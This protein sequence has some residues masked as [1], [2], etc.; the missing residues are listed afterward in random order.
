MQFG[1]VLSEL[2]IHYQDYVFM[3]IGSGKGRALIMA[4]EFPF[5]R[6]VGVELS[7]RLHEAAQSNLLR[8]RTKSRK[9][10]DIETTLADAGTFSIPTVPMVL[11]LFN[12]FDAIVMAEMLTHIAR[13][14]ERCPRHV[15]IIYT[16]PKHRKLMD[17]SGFL[18]TR[19]CEDEY[20]GCR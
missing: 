4:A 13:T 10:A 14:I 12:P 3:D 18:T 15:I 9:C 11:Y 16:N 7:E 17:D 1:V 2:K 6:I 19:S 8:A 20:P 5:K